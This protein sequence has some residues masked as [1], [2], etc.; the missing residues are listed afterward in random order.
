MSKSGIGIFVSSVMH[1]DNMVRNMMPP[2]LAGVLAIYGLVVTVLICGSLEE[3]LPLYTALLQMA[4]GVSVGV[5][6]LAAGYVLGFVW[7]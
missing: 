6:G 3:A 4:A 5:C 2:I 1:P 7:C